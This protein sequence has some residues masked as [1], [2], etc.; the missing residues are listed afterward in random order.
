[1]SLRALAYKNA[2]ILFTPPR[3][4]NSSHSI[5]ACHGFNIA[6]YLEER[7]DCHDYYCNLRRQLPEIKLGLLPRK[8]LTGFSSA[9]IV[10]G[11]HDQ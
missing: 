9:L 2:A 8:I 3:K 11:K 1:M 5:T 6:N 7:F 10:R 4:S